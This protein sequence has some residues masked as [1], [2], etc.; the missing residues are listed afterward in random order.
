MLNGL[1]VLDPSSYDLIYGPAEREEIGRLVHILG[2]PETAASVLEH[3]AKLAEVDVILSGWGAPRMDAAFLAAA[4]RLQAVFYGAGSV[5]GV[6]SDAFWD[7]GIQICTAAAANAGPVAEY[8][9][10]MIL[11]SLKHGWQS[12]QRLRQ[13]RNYAVP[14]EFPGAFGTTVGLVSLG[15]IG[16]RVRELM[17][18]FDLRVLAYDPY[19]ST[20]Q[21]AELGVTLV[22]LDRLF[23]EADVISLH[24]PWL[25]ET[26]GMVTGRHFGRM[27]P[28]AT[29]INTARGAVVREAELVATL[30]ARP[31]VYAVL[32]VTWPEPPVPESPLYTLPNVFLT[33]HIAGSMGAE[34]RRMGRC[35]V[36]ELQR[37]IAGQPLRWSVSREQLARMA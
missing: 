11:S 8:A 35:M 12:A 14:R 6:V 17:R 16:R 15:V 37:H 30:Q 23:S 1:Y 19:V 10:A 25:K 27:K 13:Q 3:P 28:G 20:A 5:R 29:F 21:A 2:P 32:D 22:D 9:L 34:C 36:E 33:P 31:D 18:P 26:E 4:P 7:R 24:T